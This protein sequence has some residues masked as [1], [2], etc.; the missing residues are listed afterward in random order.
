MSP[1]HTKD[2][3][4]WDASSRT[5]LHS[6]VGVL[7]CLGWVWGVRLCFGTLCVS[8][9]AILAK[10]RPTLA[11]Q[12]CRSPGPAWNLDGG[13]EASEEEGRRHCLERASWGQ[14]WGAGYQHGPPF[15][16]HPF[17]SPTLIFSPCRQQ[18]PFQLS[19]DPE[20]SR[21]VAGDARG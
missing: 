7:R 10:S 18:N 2:T 8:Y 13:P 5:Q 15:T 16:S 17:S 11:H 12:W 3:E 21:A 20:V 1:L 14:G 6:G 9:W 4:S 19:D